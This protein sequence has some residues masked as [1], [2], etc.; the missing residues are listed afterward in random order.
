MHRFLRD[1][2]H[3]KHSLIRSRI[4]PPCHSWPFACLVAKAFPNRY[5]LQRSPR[6]L[7]NHMW[8]GSQDSAPSKV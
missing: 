7:F 2:S 8:N 4:L 1:R 5:S 6:D 3:L